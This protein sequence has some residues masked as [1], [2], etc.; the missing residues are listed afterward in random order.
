MKNKTIKNLMVISLVLITSMVFC[1]QK[2]EEIASKHFALKE[3]NDSYSMMKMTLID[4][5]NGTKIRSFESYSMKT[6]EGK[7]TFFRFLEPSDIRDTKFLTIGHK[8]KDD[9][10]RIYLPSLKKVRLIAS[11]SGSSGKSGEFVNSDIFFYDL[12]DRSYEDYTYKYVSEDTLDGKECYVVEFFPISK[13]SPY[14]RLTAWID[15]STYVLSK[16]VAY[17]LKDELLKNILFKE[18][19]LIDGVF[20]TKRLEIENVQKNHRTVLE[21]SR[22]KINTGLDKS[23]FSIQNLSR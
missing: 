15:K 10:Q 13:T 1:D 11:S 17:D 7:N 4:K 9:E 8:D 12:E 6:N 5:N 2:G 19:V 22:I 3:S 14:S 20:V 23:I 21:A 16:F 18:N